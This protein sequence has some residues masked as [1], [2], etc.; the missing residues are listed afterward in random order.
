MTNLDY[1]PKDVERFWN[2]VAIDANSDLCWEWQAGTTRKGYGWF[3]FNKYTG[4]NSQRAAWI[5]T[6]GYI[7]NGLEVCHSC[8]NRKCCNPKH[9][10]LGTHLENMKDMTSKNRF[11]HKITYEQAIEIREL[12][13]TGNTTQQKLADKFGVCITQIHRIIHY[14]R[15][16]R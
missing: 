4:M 9:L 5:M 10:F 16:N 1:T 12:Y 7:E 8:D 2:K 6:N 15:W 3:K 14:K 13:A 11:I